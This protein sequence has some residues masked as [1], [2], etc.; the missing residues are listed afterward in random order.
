MRVDLISKQSSFLLL[1]RLK[2][3]N[4]PHNPLDTHNTLVHTYIHTCMYV[5]AMTKKSKALIREI[6]TFP[7]K[8]GL[9]QKIFQKEA[10]EIKHVFPWSKREVQ[11]ETFQ[12]E[13]LINL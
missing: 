7:L 11:L 1:K 4:T 6:L 13:A 3:K 12:K 10:L 5:P 9:Y 2:T 8:T